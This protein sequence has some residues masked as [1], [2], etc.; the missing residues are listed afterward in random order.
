MSSKL[1]MMLAGADSVLGDAMIGVV[2]LRACSWM[3]RRAVMT[4]A[5]RRG[6]D[7]DF[8]MFLLL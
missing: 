4:N 6:C 1:K 3:R 5:F 2:G 8:S 7:E